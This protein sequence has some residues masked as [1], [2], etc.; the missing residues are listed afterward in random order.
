MV[1]RAKPTRACVGVA[2]SVR[3]RDGRKGIYNGQ[4]QAQVPFWQVKGMM[5]AKW[6]G[7]VPSTSPQL[8]TH[9]CSFGQSWRG[10]HTTLPASELGLKNWQF[11]VG[12]PIKNVMA[13]TLPVY[14]APT[15]PNL[16]KRFIRQ[17]YMC[18][19]VCRVPDSPRDQLAFRGLRTAE[20]HCPRHW[21]TWRCSCS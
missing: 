14:D 16:S 17:M 7:I 11:T 1:L 3:P 2:I 5:T 9:S 4:L 19:C 6:G 20:S 13:T 8:Y 10:L 21:Q 12:N 18:V 15:V